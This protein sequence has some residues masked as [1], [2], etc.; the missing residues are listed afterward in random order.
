MCLVFC[1]L[2]YGT[3]VFFFLPKGSFI[4]ICSLTDRQLLQ[5]LRD[6]FVAGSETTATTL[7]W[8]ALYLI[9]NRDIQIKMRQE[10]ET[11]VGSGRFPS[12]DDKPRLPYCEAVI[13]EAQR[14]GNIVPNSLPHGVKYDRKYGRKKCFQLYQ[15]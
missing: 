4:Y 11:V 12:M 14:L 9:R 7:R 5:T 6:F 8:A 13:L 2:Q 15:M 3:D 10:I 1:I